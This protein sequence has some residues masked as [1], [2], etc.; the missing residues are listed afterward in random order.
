MPDFHYISSQVLDLATIIDIIDH[1]KQLALSDEAV[2]NIKKS[3]AYLDTKILNN[4]T[5]IYGI[6]TG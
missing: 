2:L 6:N 3:R 1:Q 5:P 4:E